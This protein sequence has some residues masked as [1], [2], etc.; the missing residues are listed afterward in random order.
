[1]CDGVEIIHMIQLYTESSIDLSSPGWSTLAGSS[2]SHMRRTL[3]PPKHTIFVSWN[4]PCVCVGR[5]CYLFHCKT[6][7]VIEIGPKTVGLVNDPKAVGLV[8]DPSD[9]LYG[10]HTPA[11]EVYISDNVMPCIDPLTIK[12]S[13]HVV[14]QGWLK[15]FCCPG[16]LDPMLLPPWTWMQ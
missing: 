2:S 8:N 9:L 1:M 14:E 12:C 11:E 15:A 7:M 16:Y 10:V 5:C 6:Y 4:S 3:S 13:N